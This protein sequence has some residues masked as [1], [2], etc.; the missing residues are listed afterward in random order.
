MN[1]KTKDAVRYLT[2][3]HV[4]SITLAAQNGSTLSDG[5]HIAIA[6]H[7]LAFQM[8]EVAAALGRIYMTLERRDSAKT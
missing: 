6:T 3:Q 2:E 7:A 1:T 8:Y 4:A 5:Q